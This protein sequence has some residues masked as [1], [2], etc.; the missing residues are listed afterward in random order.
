MFSQQIGLEFNVAGLVNAVH[1]PES[2]CD[3]EVGADFSQGIV[4]IPN[5]FRL[6]VQAG[7]I[8]VTVVNAV[9][10]ATGDADLHLK[11]QS[12]GRHA[13]EVFDARRD[14]LILGLLREIEHVGREQWLLVLFEVGLVS[15][16]HSIEPGKEFVGTVVTVKDDRA[17]KG[18]MS[19][20]W[21]PERF[22]LHAVSL[23]DNA[24]MVRCSNGTCDRG[25]LLVV[26]ETLASEVCATALR[27]LD[28]DGGF[29]VPLIQIRPA[30]GSNRYIIPCGFENGVGGGRRGHILRRPVRRHLEKNCEETH[31]GLKC[32]SVRD[33][34]N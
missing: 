1:V 8:N 24:Y 14:I 5:V 10:L 6:S 7:V 19:T 33:P 30:R 23:G 12:N 20:F 29:Y 4:D 15:L 2:R 25:L 21:S 28:D 17:G 31:D 32:I 16:E 11:P 27:N 22:H 34:T 9:L 18:T 13:L 26:G 3:T